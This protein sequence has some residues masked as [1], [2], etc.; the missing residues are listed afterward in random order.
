M[1][2]GISDW[3][4]LF[5][6]GFLVYFIRTSNGMIKYLLD[7]EDVKSLKIGVWGVPM[8]KERRVSMFH[9]FF[10]LFLLYFS[11]LL[12]GMDFNLFLVKLQS[13]LL[14]KSLHFLFSRLG[15]CGGGLVIA[16]VLTILDPE[17]AKMMAPG[18][19]EGGSGASSSKQ[20]SFDLNVPP[21]GRDELSSVMYELSEVERRIQQAE[22]GIQQS[23]LEIE[24]LNESRVQVLQASQ[25]AREGPRDQPAP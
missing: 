9:F 24:G 2:Q 10:P 20:P 8:T 18:G 17:L 12:I 21:G 22:T 6:L 1:M 23:L 16:V 3:S 25:E 13:I 5:I 7:R 14:T 15:W 11:F 4:V 19:E